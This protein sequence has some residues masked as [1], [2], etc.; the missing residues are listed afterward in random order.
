MNRINL[1]HPFHFI[2]SKKKILMLL[3]RSIYISY[4]THTE[5]CQKRWNLFPF[6]NLIHRL[7]S[8]SF[9]EWYLLREYMNFTKR[10]ILFGFCFCNFLRLLSNICFAENYFIFNVIIAK[11]ITHF[12]WWFHYLSFIYNIDVFIIHKLFMVAI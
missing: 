3:N 9:C 6:L 11:Y 7:P 5:P 8:V 12:T 4:N 10:V 1:Q 2:C